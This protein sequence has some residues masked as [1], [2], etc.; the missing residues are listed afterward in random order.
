MPSNIRLEIHWKKCLYEE[1]IVSTA[2]LR[3][4]GMGYER[5]E[6][7]KINVLEMKYLRSLVECH[8]WIELGM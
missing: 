4:R 6:R 3:S 2:L 7:S 5:G 8:E 1:V